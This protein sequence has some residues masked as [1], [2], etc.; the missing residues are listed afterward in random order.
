MSNSVYVVQNY[1]RGGHEYN[2][3]AVFSTEALA[4]QWIE[5]QDEG[6]FDDYDVLKEDFNPIP[7]KK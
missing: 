3:S 4:Q 2:V 5:A 7:E 1:W 6:E